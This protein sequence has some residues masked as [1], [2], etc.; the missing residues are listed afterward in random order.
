MSKETA[1]HSRTSALTRNMVEYKG[2]WLPQAYREG[3]IAEYWACRQKAAVIDLSPL[4]K[5]EVTG[6]DSGGAA[7]VLPDPGREKA[8]PRPG[9]LFR[10]VL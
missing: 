3:P 9:R 1:F 6:P 10:D 8:E 7:A 5:W 2:Y 4:R